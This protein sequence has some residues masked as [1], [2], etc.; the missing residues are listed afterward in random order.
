MGGVFQDF[1]KSFLSMTDK[2]FLNILPTCSLLNKQD[3]KILIDKLKDLDFL[4][5]DFKAA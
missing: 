5:K 3:E 4:K 2:Q 1:L